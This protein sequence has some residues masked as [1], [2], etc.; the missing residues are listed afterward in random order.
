M[1]IL[2]SMSGKKEKNSF[3]RDTDQNIEKLS[4]P[5]NYP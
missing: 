5:S 1:K 3:Q 4:T 2:K